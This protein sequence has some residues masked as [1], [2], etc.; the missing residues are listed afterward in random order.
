[1]IF[2]TALSPRRQFVRAQTIKGVIGLLLC[3]S[4]GVLVGGPGL[5]EALVFTVVMAPLGLA[6]LGLSPLSLRTLEAAS[7]AVNA[8]LLSV[9]IL[10]TRGL[11]LPFSALL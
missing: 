5:D 1:M 8:V 6:S 4:Y 11:F 9:L 7:V 2:T 3:L 10:F